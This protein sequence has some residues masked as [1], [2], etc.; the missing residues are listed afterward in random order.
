MKP[1]SF[2]E[3][4]ADLK[5]ASDDHS[6]SFVYTKEES[7]FFGRFLG[8]KNVSN[9]AGV[10]VIYGKRGI[11]Q[12]LLYIG[13]S[14]TIRRA[15]KLGSQGLVTRINK[16]DSKT[17][18]GKALMRQ[19]VFRVFVDHPAAEKDERENVEKAY[20]FI[21]NEGSYDG[22]EFHLIETYKNKVGTPPALA[23]AQLLWAYLFEHEDLP[24]M[25]Q[26]F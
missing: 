2:E 1:K 4:W 25:N 17:E 24:K 23:E 11:T 8:Q 13:K 26:V 12:E 14:G 3:T 5:Q 10:Y 7:K 21:Q 16:K 22:L 9:G 15:G 20:P 19:S 6:W 18:E